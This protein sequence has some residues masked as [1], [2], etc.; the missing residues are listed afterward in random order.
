MLMSQPDFTRQAFIILLQSPRGSHCALLCPQLDFSDIIKDRQR[1]PVGSSCRA[2]GA[3]GLILK[4]CGQSREPCMQ[5][6]ER[7]ETCPEHQLPDP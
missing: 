6:K 1:F 5:R 2:S 7:K 3:E 4:L